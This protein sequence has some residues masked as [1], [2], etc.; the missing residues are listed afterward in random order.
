MD[1]TLLRTAFFLEMIEVDYSSF[2]TDTFK[3]MINDKAFKEY[4]Y[5]AKM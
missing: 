5:G 4:R 1:K 2:L 3:Q